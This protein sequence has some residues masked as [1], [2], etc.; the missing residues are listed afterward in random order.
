MG[1]ALLKRNMNKFLF[2]LEEEDGP[3]NCVNGIKLLLDCITRLFDSNK[4]SRTLIE[5]PFHFADLINKDIYISAPPSY[6]ENYLY[7]TLKQIICKD[8]VVIDIKNKE[9]LKI[10]KGK[11]LPMVI[12]FND[13]PIHIYENDEGMKRKMETISIFN[14]LHRK[15]YKKYLKDMTFFYKEKEAIKTKLISMFKN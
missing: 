9:N 1:A 4:V 7:I 10:T 6:G 13:E 11:D 14:T 12:L 8:D 5:S 2:L 3:E 15:N